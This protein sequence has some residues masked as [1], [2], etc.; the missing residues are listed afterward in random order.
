MPAAASVGQAGSEAPPAL[1]PAKPITSRFSL[2]M[3]ESPLP[4]GTPAEPAWIGQAIVLG[5]GATAEALRRRL[6]RSGATVHMLA[7]ESAM[8]TRSWPSWKRFAAVDRRP[9]CF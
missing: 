9:I 2:E 5:T 8:P 4:P 6:E 1:L 3:R 7:A